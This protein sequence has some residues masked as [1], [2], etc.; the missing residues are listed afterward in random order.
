MLR[1]TMVILAVAFA[2]GGSALSTSAFAFGRSYGGGLR[3]SGGNAS[4]SGVGNFH[5]G[6]RQNQARRYKRDPWGHWGAYYGPMIT[7]P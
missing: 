1:K 3:A 6:V 7:V 5:R 4:Q 2:L